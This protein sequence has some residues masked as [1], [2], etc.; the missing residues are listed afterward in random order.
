MTKGLKKTAFVYDFD[1]TR[2]WPGATFK[3]T[4]SSRNW[5]WRPGVLG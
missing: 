4:R 1:G 5:S 3:S 2:L